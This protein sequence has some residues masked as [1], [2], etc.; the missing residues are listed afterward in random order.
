[1]IRDRIL[2]SGGE[3]LGVFPFGILADNEELIPTPADQIVRGT[4]GVF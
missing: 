1:M 3:S 2:Q 4:A